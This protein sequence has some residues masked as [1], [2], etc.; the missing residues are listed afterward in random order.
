VVRLLAWALAGAL[1]AA[2][3]ARAHPLAPALLEL[4]E[5]P[6]GRVDVGWKRPLMR[7]PGDT[8]APELPARCTPVGDRAVSQEG[9]GVWTRWV[10]DC[11]P[12]G[13]V[14]GQIGV[15]G[16]GGLGIGALV[17][18]T[19]ADGRVVERVLTPARPALTVPAEPRVLDVVRDYA[20]LGVEH[21]LTGPD[22]VLFV[23]GLVLLAATTRRLLATVTAFTV[24]HSVT[25]TLAALGLVDLPSRAIEVGIAASV[26]ALAVELARRPTRPTMMRRRPWLMAAAFGLLHGLGFAAALRD[27]GLPAGAIPLALFS[28]NL[29]IEIGQVLFVLVVLAVGRMLGR[30]AGEMPAWARRV[31]LYVMGSLAASWWLER[32]LALLR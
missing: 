11:G 8:Q 15:T 13:L 32:T 21:I 28:F 1:A 3:A 29:G 12:A 26:L 16:G 4:H 24:G 6:G 14:G 22:H 2:P 23:F 10:V 27:A 25:L 9:G 18:V 20:R 31:P 30:V 19:L 7:P 5:H 17:R